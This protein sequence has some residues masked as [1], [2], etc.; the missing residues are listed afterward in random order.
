[1]NGVTLD[2]ATLGTIRPENSGAVRDATSFS[3][4]LH[5]DTQVSDRLGMSGGKSPRQAQN[6]LSGERKK[7]PTITHHALSPPPS[8]HHLYIMHLN[9]GLTKTFLARLLILI[10]KGGLLQL[11]FG[12]VG[13]GVDVGVNFYLWAR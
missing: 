6:P 13:I 3:I 7:A 1:M 12:S 5:G 11:K 2:I 8:H 4:K 10:K 9:N